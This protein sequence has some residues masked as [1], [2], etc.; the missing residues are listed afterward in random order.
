MKKVV[1]IPARFQS[2]RLP[3]KPL[4]D[5]FGKPMIVRVCES[6]DKKQF[7]QVCVATDD[8]RILK[9]VKDSGFHAVMTSDQHVSGT[10][11]LFEASQTLNL[12]PEDIVINLQGDEPLM[13]TSNLT[14][15]ADL[16]M[17]H[18]QASVSTVY[19]PMARDQITNPN[20]VKMVADVNQRVL[21]FSRAA[22]PFDRDGT[23]TA[24]ADVS[25]KRHVGLYAYRQSAL[26]A[27]NDYPESA[28]ER[29]EKLEQLR[30]ME[31]GYVIVADVAYESVPAGVD[32][33]E[34]LESVRLV[35]KKRY[36]L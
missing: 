23:E 26:A 16:L 9:A 35:Y 27:F 2:T 32:T 7:D 24:S 34:D 30:F 29:L 25:V 6:V 20:A 8:E 18:P 5:I 3:G 28:L 11:R 1:I 33:L 13:P 17:A 14:Q 10:D 12:A 21:Y 22:I 15:V 4:K 19:E 31:N 36:S